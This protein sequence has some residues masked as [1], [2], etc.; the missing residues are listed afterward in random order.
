[1]ATLAELARDYTALEGPILA[2]LQR[3]VGSWGM[4]S[5]L[6]FADLL[7][8]VPVTERTDRFIVLG[9]VRPTT[10]QTLHREDLVGHVIDDVERP[11]VA[12]AWRL[13]S[14]V[15]GEV[16]IPSRSERGRMVCIPVRWHGKLVAVLESGFADALDFARDKHAK[17]IFRHRRPRDIPERVE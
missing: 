5:D 8:F 1:M 6:C 11:L 7:L 16:D 4:L 10:S 2:H 9:Q 12:R 3:L 14:I 13:A 17:I 15:E